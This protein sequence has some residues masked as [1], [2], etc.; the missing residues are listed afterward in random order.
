MQENEILDPKSIYVLN[1]KG[2]VLAVF[3]KDD[4]D[5]LIDPEIQEIQNQEARLTFQVPASS[6]KWT[7]TYNPENL[8]LTQHMLFSANFSDCV[9]TVLNERGEELVS[10]QAYEAQKLLEREYVRVYN[11]TTGFEEVDDLG[12]PIKDGELYIDEFMVIVLSNGDKEL[13]NGPKGEELVVKSTHEKGTSGYALDAILYGTGWTT[14][15]CDVEG[16][17]DLETDQ[18]T[19]YENIAKIQELW[20]GILVVDSI[21]KTISHRDETKYLPYTGYQVKEEKNLQTYEYIGDNKIITALCPLGNGSLNIKS[22]N[23]GSVWLTNFSYTDTIYKSIEN[24]EDIYDVEQLK[25][26]GERKLQELCK[27]RKELSVTFPLLEQLEEFKHEEIGINHIIDI[28][29]YNLEEEKVSQ[30]RVIEFTRK[31]WSLEDANIVVGD[32]TLD[33]TDIFKKNVQATNLVNNG[34]LDTSKIIDYYKNGRSLRETL[35]EVDRVIIQTKSDLSK[36]DDE[37]RAAVEQIETDVDTL[38]NDIVSQSKTIAELLISVGEI[39]SEVK[40]LA[41]LTETITSYTGK[42]LL[43]DAIAGY[44]YGISVHGYEG[45][46]KGTILGYESVIGNDLLLLDRSI[47]MKVYSKNIIPTTKDYYITQPIQVDSPDQDNPDVI[48]MNTKYP[49]YFVELKEPIRVEPGQDFYCSLNLTE[50]SSDYAFHDVLLFDQNLHPVSSW[51]VRAIK[52]WVQGISDRRILGRTEQWITIPDNVY[53]LSYRIYKKYSG[54][55]EDHPLEYFNLDT[56]II[57]EIKPQIEFGT[58]KTEFT[59]HSYNKYEFP[60]DD[61]LR[62]MTSVNEDGDTVVDVYDEFTIL[63]KNAQLIRRIGVDADGNKYKLT[64]PE[65]TNYGTIDIPIIKGDNYVEI[66]GYNPTITVQYVKQNSYTDVFATKVEVGTVIKQTDELILLTATKMVTKDKLIQ[67][68]NS[69]I[70]ISPEKILIEGDKIIIKSS[71]FELTED[72][73]I[74][75]TAGTI[76]GWEITENALYKNKAGLLSGSGDD[77][78][79]LFAGADT[80]TINEDGTI[81]PNKPDIVIKNKGVIDVYP[82]TLYENLNIIKKVNGSNTH[83]IVMSQ[84]ARLASAKG[85][86]LFYPPG[87]YTGS[88]VTD[89]SC[90]STLFTNTG[91]FHWLANKNP[92]SYAG[93]ITANNTDTPDHY[94]ICISNALSFRVWDILHPNL[95]A[96]FALYRTGNNGEAS[97]AEFNVSNVYING[98]QVSTNSSDERLKMNI[99]DAIENALNLINAILHRRFD[100]KKDGK[101]ISIGYIAQELM[102]VDPNFVIYNKDY[103]TYQIDLLYLIATATKA[104]Q[105]EDEKV[106]K[107]KKENEKLKEIVKMFG[108]K[109]GMANEVNDILNK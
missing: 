54:S 4:E 94:A 32:I 100:W 55:L 86:R 31:I 102:K 12:K 36:T 93:V 65:I 11:S 62:E 25:K 77:D 10:V 87:T 51:N 39:K 5:T 2:G 27:P 92:W 24:N 38:N 69:Q 71:Y 44:L 85:L 68:F 30:L 107:L 40:T 97:K 50:N 37:I 108:D 21:N 73:K 84:D 13:L 47:I 74:I 6:K 20:G 81:T 43:E 59:E 79:I 22:K 61:E 91:I 72:G 7:S 60:L 19:V 63:D 45:S 34:T 46:F 53:Y 8:Y 14:G 101:H 28:K 42:I 57:E 41:D 58:S 35:R 89:A 88:G 106:E 90:A 96:M 99:M 105:E 83:P 78:I 17:Y 56:S 18:L 1:K 95:P 9:K 16:K 3:N 66:V 103:D 48:E 15:I 80:V 104:I 70:A 82:N 33:S 75:A 23:D 29:N 52:D 76:A 49:N 26:W 64:V 109:L 98:N 67:E